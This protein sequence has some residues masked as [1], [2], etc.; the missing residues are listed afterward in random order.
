MIAFI[1][2]LRIYTCIAIGPHP[3]LADHS[4]KR[5]RE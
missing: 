3:R 2:R 4:H 1:L 5:N